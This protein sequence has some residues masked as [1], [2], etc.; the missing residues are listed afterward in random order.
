MEGCH[1]LQGSYLK[2]IMAIIVMVKLRQ[3]EI[4][5]TSYTGEYYKS[6]DE[7]AKGIMPF[8]AFQDQGNE[9]LSTLLNATANSTGLNF[10]ITDI[11]EGA[12]YNTKD[13]VPKVRDV[14]VCSTV[15][16][17]Q[18]PGSLKGDPGN[19]EKREILKDGNL[20]LA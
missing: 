17:A 7:N 12:V 19:P 11:I 18:K 4:S 10:K 6:L 2:I 8:N 3:K 9:P 5:S 14:R 1:L 16:I 13:Q 20:E 15:H